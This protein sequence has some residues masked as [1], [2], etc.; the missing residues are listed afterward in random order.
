MKEK[1]FFACAFAI[2]ALLF[3]AVACQQETADI[4]S[5][6][7]PEAPAAVET[8]STPPVS[9][10]GDPT[11]EV[12][13]S[14]SKIEMPATLQAGAQN[15]SVSNEG[16]TAL[17]FSI[18]GENLDNEF[19]TPLQPGET[20]SM[21]VDLKPGTYTVTTGSGDPSQSANTLQITVQ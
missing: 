17:N 7:D 2:S 15:I 11:V 19:A 20:R 3:G 5:A 18:E 9:G 21:L 4:S 1:R 14:D 13:L 6:H 8:P 16:Q 10:P 12:T